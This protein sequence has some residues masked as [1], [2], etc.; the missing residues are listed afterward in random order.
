M[1]CPSHDPPLSDREKLSST[2]GI[3]LQLLQPRTLLQETLVMKVTLCI[4]FAT[5]HH[6]PE[7]PIL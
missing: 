2:H 7:N 6:V 5:C 1:L 3:L 4:L